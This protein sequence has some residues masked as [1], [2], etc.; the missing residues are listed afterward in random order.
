MRREF[1]RFGVPEENIHATKETVRRQALHDLHSYV[2]TRK[3]VATLAPKEITEIL[4][5]WMCR[6]PIEIVPSR[7]Q[8]IEVKIV[9][10]A[11]PDASELSRLMTMCDHYINNG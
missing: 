6:S 3:E 10:L 4:T 7:S 11:R 2:P 9:L 5:G 8:I 1:D